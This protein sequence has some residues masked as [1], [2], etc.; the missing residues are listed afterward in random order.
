MDSHPA[1]A[2]VVTKFSQAQVVA[3]SDGKRLHNYLD[4]ETAACT[5]PGCA[6]VCISPGY[7]KF[8]RH[9]L[10]TNYMYYVIYTNNDD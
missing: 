7:D 10:H 6:K 2:Q 4:Y 3:N 8:Y 5:S 1:Q 9:S